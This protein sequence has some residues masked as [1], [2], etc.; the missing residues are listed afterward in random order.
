MATLTRAEAAEVLEHVAVRLRARGKVAPEA[1]AASDLVREV[2]VE[3]SREL[4][5]HEQDAVRCARS[6][7][8]HVRASLALATV[9]AREDV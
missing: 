4:E 1:V 2:L 8:W 7:T 9:L 3:V 5:R 6:S